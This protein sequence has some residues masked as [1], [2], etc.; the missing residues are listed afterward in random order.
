MKGPN[1]KQ[2]AGSTRVLTTSST[3]QPMRTTLKREKR[4]VWEKI[5]HNNNPMNRHIREWVGQHVQP[6]RLLKDML[7]EGFITKIEYIEER[8]RTL[9]KLT[10]AKQIW[11]ED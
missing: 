11:L 3:G 1:A 9:R 8:G 5:H 10:P 2:N 6:K 4:I 7:R